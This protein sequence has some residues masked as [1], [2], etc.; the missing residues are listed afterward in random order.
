M[1]ILY[2]ILYQVNYDKAKLYRIGS[3]A[4]SDAKIYTIKEFTWTSEPIDILG[5]L[6]SNDVEL[7]TELNQKQILTKQWH[8]QDFPY[9]GRAPVR[10]AWT[11]NAGT[12]Q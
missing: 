2:L 12:F 8:I 7:I 6:I 10:G 9:G 3:L 1:I 11:S 4:N 5:I